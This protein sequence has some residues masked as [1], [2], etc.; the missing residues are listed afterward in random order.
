M[1]ADEDMDPELAA[2]VPLPIGVPFSSDGDSAD[3][4]LAKMDEDVEGIERE[5]G[6]A[7]RLVTE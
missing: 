2:V 5:R 6:R 1:L 7:L 3:P 4:E